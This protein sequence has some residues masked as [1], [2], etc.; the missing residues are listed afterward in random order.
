MALTRKTD[1]QKQ[2]VIDL[3]LKLK[4]KLPVTNFFGDDNHK[5]IDLQIKVLKDE[6]SEGQIWSYG[7][8]IAS[9]LLDVFEWM[10]GEKD[11]WLDDLKSEFE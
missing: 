8:S 3:L 4:E 7:D 1:K 5:V 10:R 6:I 11:D 2:E 9:Q